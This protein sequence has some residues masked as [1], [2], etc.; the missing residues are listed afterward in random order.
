MIVV[1]M[2]VSGAGKSHIGR[3]IADRMGCAFIE[4]DDLHPESNRRKMAAGTPLTDA[5]RAPWLD[6]IASE[7]AR[8]DAAGESAVVACSALR[9]R[10]RD[11]LR[12]CGAPVHFLHLTGDPALIRARMERRSDHFMP[13]ALLDSQLATLEPAAAHETL[14]PIDIAQ[15]PEA[16]ADQAIRILRS[17]QTRI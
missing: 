14:L 12:A 8:I 4:G 10:Y 7:M 1:A 5:D 3:L 15:T 13:S 2:G 11:R 9:R 16:I 6:R 17:A